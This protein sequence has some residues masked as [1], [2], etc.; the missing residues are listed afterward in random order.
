MVFQGGAVLAE[1][2]KNNDSFWLSKAEWQEEGPRALEKFGSSG[3][4]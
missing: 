4:K 2:M 3:G 1:L